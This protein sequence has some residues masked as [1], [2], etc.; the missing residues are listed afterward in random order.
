MVRDLL[1]QKILDYSIAWVKIE[2]LNGMSLTITVCTILGGKIESNRL[3]V[4]S[5]PVDEK[6]FSSDFEIYKVSMIKL[7]GRYTLIFFIRM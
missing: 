1:W 2:A 4:L 5:F 7:I 3:C 6:G